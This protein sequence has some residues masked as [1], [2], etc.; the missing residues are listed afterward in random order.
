[1]WGRQRGLPADGEQQKDH[2]GCTAT[3]DGKSVVDFPPGEILNGFL[4]PLA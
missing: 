1:M 2:N 4:K 3:S